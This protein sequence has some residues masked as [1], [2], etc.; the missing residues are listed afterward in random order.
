MD[1]VKK[2]TTC[3]LPGHGHVTIRLQA[4]SDVVSPRPLWLGALTQTILSLKKLHYF[5]T[6][7]LHKGAFSDKHSL[8]FSEP[9]F[10][11]AKVLVIMHK[12][13]FHSNAVYL[14]YQ[15]GYQ[16]HTI[17]Y[18]H[19][20]F[21]ACAACARLFAGNRNMPSCHPETSHIAGLPQ[22]EGW[23]KGKLAPPAA[24]PC[25]CSCAQPAFWSQSTRLAQH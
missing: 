25:P 8:S 11:S 13:Y 21:I 6:F 4:S 2:K 10:Y 5:T 24:V 15:H 1:V 12:A 18:G 20:T 3:T 22:S 16:G 7:C 9:F 17:Q 23:R 14:H 19:N